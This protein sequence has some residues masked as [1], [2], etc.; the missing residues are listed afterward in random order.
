MLP[1]INRTCSWA[2]LCILLVCAASCSVIPD[3][4]HTQWHMLHPGITRDV[5]LMFN[6]LR[7]QSPTPLTEDLDTTR[8]KLDR[9]K[10]DSLFLYALDVAHG[11][12]LRACALAGLACLTHRGIPLRFGLNVPLTFENDSLLD[13]RFNR[14]PR[15][16]FKDSPVEGDSDKLQHFFMSAWLAMRSDSP[17]LSNFAG[18][19]IEGGEAL[20]ID[21]R[22]DDERDLRA[23]ALGRRFA[24]ALQLDSKTL[25]SQVLRMDDE[26][27]PER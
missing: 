17:M 27:T 21:A 4:R 12:Y 19:V 24:R 6:Y 9:Q 23:N 16:L 1:V 15:Y 25:P 26:T 18:H 2:I 11:D 20:L 8:I 14:M 13:R 22:Q 10:V 7:D 3:G 5:P